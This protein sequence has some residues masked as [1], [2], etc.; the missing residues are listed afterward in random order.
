LKLTYKNIRFSDEQK[1]TFEKKFNFTDKKGETSNSLAK[2]MKA[3]SQDDPVP[4]LDVC[5]ADDALEHLLVRDQVEVVQLLVRSQ[6]V[7]LK[8]NIVIQIYFNF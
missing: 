2:G 4:G 7:S 1:L 5:V 6:T 8:F 3:F